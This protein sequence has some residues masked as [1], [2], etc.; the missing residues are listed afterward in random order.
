MRAS[1]FATNQMNRSDLILRLAER[2]PQL[3]LK[4]AEISAVTILGSIGEALARG[5]RVE[6]RGFGS[7]SLNH[8]PERVARNPKTGEKVHVPPKS[9]PHFKA[10]KELRERVDAKTRR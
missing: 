10:G 7:F 8:R 2:F 6:I 3:A 9:M 1:I 5:G 4:D